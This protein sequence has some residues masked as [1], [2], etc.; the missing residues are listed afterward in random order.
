MAKIS[1]AKVIDTL[2]NLPDQIWQGPLI[3]Y[4]KEYKDA[5]KRIR[6]GQSGLIDE[7]SDLARAEGEDYLD[8]EAEKRP[9]EIAKMRERIEKLNKLVKSVGEKVA[10]VVKTVAGYKAFKEGLQVIASLGEKANLISA[11]S[12]PITAPGAP[13][14]GGPFAVLGFIKRYAAKSAIQLS[15]W[16]N[17][18]LATLE[19][20][21][22]HLLK[23][24][25]TI[26]KGMS[27][28]VSGFFGARAARVVRAEKWGR[29]LDDDVVRAQEEADDAEAAAEND[30]R[31]YQIAA[32]ESYM[33]QL[34]EI[35]TDALNDDFDDF[36]DDDE[37]GEFD[38]EGLFDVD[39]SD[40]DPDLG[41]ET[42]TNPGYPFT[43]ANF[44]RTPFGSYGS[45]ADA[46]QALAQKYGFSTYNEYKQGRSLTVRKSEWD[47]SSDIW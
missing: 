29:A 30:E 31:N 18:A 22:L 38:E 28:A 17:T 34:I 33:D 35:E 4:R 16:A 15:F 25:Q 41:E 14:A 19:G 20:Q 8:R 39:V 45:A 24:G 36:L 12:A 23:F 9:E 21:E 44:S 11:A 5:V 6:R 27:K 46:R 3:Q 10:M 37:E 13:A 40:F 7:V 47:G 32:G 26:L 42:D 43:E 2:L 1:K